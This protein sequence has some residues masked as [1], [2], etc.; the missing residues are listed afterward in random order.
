[1]NVPRDKILLVGR[2]S[3]GIGP[4]S[5]RCR[6]HAKRS[7]ARCFD[8]ACAALSAWAGRLFLWPA[9]ALYVGPAADTTVHAHHALQICLGLGAPFRLRVGTRTPW[10]QY[11]LAWVKPD[12]WHQLDGG[13]ADVAL[14]YV[15][16]ES[17][18]GRALGRSAPCSAFALPHAGDLQPLQER[19][20]G[21]VDPGGPAQA[22]AEAVREFLGVVVSTEPPPSPVDSRVTRVLAHLRSCRERRLSAGE[23]AA[24]VGLSSHRFQHLFRDATGV[25]FRRYLLWLR[26]IE[27]VQIAGAGGS[28][29]DA[30]HAAGF[31]D[32]AHLSRTFRR[33]FGLAPSALTKHSAFVQAPGPPSA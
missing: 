8:T 15:E 9:Y 23:V 3:E 7:R 14:L 30:A 27:A 28:L 13:G 19:L 22:A 26:L 20:R 2:F 31:A 5:H 12:R 18:E 24:L 11:E 32:S 17:P 33:M 1:M 16:P 21:C 10:R 4:P 6:A 29:T 25:P